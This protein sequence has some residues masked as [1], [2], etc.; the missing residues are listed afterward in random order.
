MGAKVKFKNKRLISGEE[1]ADICVESQKNFKSINCPKKLNSNAI[2]EFLVIFLLAAKANGVS[3]FSNL[4][5]LNK[6]ESPRLKL[7]SKILNMMGVKTILTNS[8]LKIFGNPSLELNKRIEI[9]NYFKDHR[10]FMT[11]VIA[12]LAFGGKWL[13][14]DADSY[15]SSF[16]SFLRIIRKFGHKFKIN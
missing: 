8:S 16:P 9:K 3:T 6:K 14:H 5:E 12:A 1:V 13:I 2:D 4:E 7:G 15:K 10:I 11:S